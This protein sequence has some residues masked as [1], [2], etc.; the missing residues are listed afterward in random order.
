MERCFCLKC[1]NRRGISANSRLY[2][3]HLIPAAGCRGQSLPANE[4]KKFSPFPSGRGAGGWGEK[5]FAEKLTAELQIIIA[6]SRG[7]NPRKH[8]FFCPNRLNTTQKAVFALFVSIFRCHNVQRNG[9]AVGGIG[10]NSAH[11]LTRTGCLC[12]NIP[13]Q[14]I[15]KKI[16]KRRHRFFSDNERL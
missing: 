9:H 15:Y 5:S 1:I 7:Q 16:L 2:A 3:K 12:Y 6:Y 10:E 14:I 13:C 4:I 8:R 11:F